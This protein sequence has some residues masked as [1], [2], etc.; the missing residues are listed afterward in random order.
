MRAI[1]DTDLLVAESLS[2]RGYELAVSSLPWAE[3]GYG[4][5]SVWDPIERARRES[6]VA[7]LVSTGRCER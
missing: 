3:L 4:L 7:R 2:H 1:F 6:R 5:R